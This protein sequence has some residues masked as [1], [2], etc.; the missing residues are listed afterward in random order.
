ML[1]LTRKK[2][3]SF[4]IND[5]IKITIRDTGNDT[6]RIAIDAPREVK[7]L[8]EELAEAARI[9]AEAAEQDR[10]EAEDIRRIFALQK[11]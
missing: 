2:G 8:R 3:Q 9:N 7:I 5:N 10:V 1:I 6:V 4:F 11:K